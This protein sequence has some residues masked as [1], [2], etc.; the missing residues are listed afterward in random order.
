MPEL[1]CYF[2]DMLTAITGATHETGWR[3]LTI[4]WGVTVTQFSGF[5]AV[6]IEQP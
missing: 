2:I 6:T 5:W 3:D 1:M 4:Y